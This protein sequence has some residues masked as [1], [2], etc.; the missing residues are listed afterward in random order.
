MT[1]DFDR[2]GVALLT[3]NPTTIYQVPSDAAGATSLVLS[4]LAAHVADSTATASIELRIVSAA[5][6][7]LGTPV[8]RALIGP[9]MAVELIPNRHVLG[10]GE[11]VQA[12]ASTGGLLSVLISVLGPALSPSR[13]GMANVGAYARFV[14][15]E[16]VGSNKNIVDV[17]PIIDVDV[18]FWAPA[19]RV[20][21]AVRP[22]ALTVT[23]AT[24]APVLALGP[25]TVSAPK[26]SIALSPG[27]PS[28]ATGSATA[29]PLS[30][31]TLSAPVPSVTAA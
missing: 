22:P 30:Q 20:G 10:P 16:T 3:A 6:Q 4:C 23:A 14:P 5:G 11:R 27:V 18:T 29:V 24:V 7:V 17:D 8:R 9:R 13:R 12:T 25:V 26:S 21:A 19:I 28:I 15:P 2:S 1:E 31:I